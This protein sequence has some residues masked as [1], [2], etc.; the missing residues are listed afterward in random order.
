[1][2]T[3]A[4]PTGLQ[5]LGSF[6]AVVSISFDEIVRDYGGGYDT[7]ELV[8][9]TAGLI[10]LRL[11]LDFLDDSGQLTVVDAENANAVTNWSQYLWK[12]FIRRKQDGAAFNVAFTDPDDGMSRT[13]TFKFMESRLDYTWFN[14]KL[15][16]T[17]LTLRQFVALA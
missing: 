6:G 14:V 9:P 12:F 15:Y 5:A 7:T 17:G 1:M 8:G 16:S 13:D 2:A 11:Q 4:V 3:L 10:Y